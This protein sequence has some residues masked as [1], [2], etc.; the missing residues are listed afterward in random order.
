M[1]W[2]LSEVV[3]ENDDSPDRT[4]R[5]RLVLNSLPVL[6]STHATDDEGTYTGVYTTLQVKSTSSPEE[7]IGSTLSDVLNGE[8]TEKLLSSI[9]NA[10]ES[11]ERQYA[12]FPVYF[13]GE[14]FWRGAYISPLSSETDQVI[15][16]SFDLTR[17]HELEKSIY[18]VLNALVTYSSRRDLEEAFCE[19]LVEMDRYEAAWI[20][21]GDGDVEVRA[22]AGTSGY[23]E[24]L[25]ERFC[26]LDEADE[27]GVSAVSSGEP[28]DVFSTKNTKVWGEIASEHGIQAGVA[29]PLSH[30][31]VE[32]GTL[33]VYT[34]DTKYLAPWRR[35]ILADYADAIG[36][37]LSAAMW[38]WAL[39]AKA[40]AVVD[41]EFTGS[42]L[43]E[44]CAAA[45]CESCEVESVVPQS[46]GTVYYL[47]TD[48]SFKPE[49]IA[50]GFERVRPYGDSSRDA[51]A[52]LIEEVTPE[53]EIAQKGGRI[54]KF[55]VT[56]ETVEI[57][58]VVPDPE[59]LRTMTEEFQ[60]RY[61]NAS[62][63]VEWGEEGGY[64]SSVSTPE[65]ALTER[66]YEVLE[67]AYRHGYFDADSGCNLT[68]LADNL[69]IS[70][71][72]VSEHLQAAQRK[73]FSRMLD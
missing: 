60:D 8:A 19:R 2:S 51:R 33:V 69:D 48:S 28:T 36:Y 56:Q 16:A 62:V 57:S 31:G 3:T 40:A 1:L 23:L 27:P 61:S 63:S 11:G 53:R 49:D 59:G 9:D 50:R 35:D 15:I 73:L 29:L 13:A 52:I 6:V 54:R 24:A 64:I 4:G 45:G 25:D 18:D 68:E 20:G 7:L 44:L 22:S 38:R 12:E 46:D 14:E 21:K 41:I 43:S 66:Q 58:V 67:A 30:E 65:S 72:T 32:H 10:V 5:H 47:S 70:R 37:A 26:S 17:H 71:W 39:T 34:S 55:Q 42:K